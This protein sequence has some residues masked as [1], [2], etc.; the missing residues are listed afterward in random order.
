MEAS[1]WQTISI[2]G[3]S[4][5]AVLFIGAII[6]FFKLNIR[7]IIGDLTGRSAAKQIQ[8]IREQNAMSGNKRY[9]PGA[10]NLERGELTEPVKVR[11]GLFSGRFGK[12]SGSALTQASET[13]EGRG[14]T[15][16]QRPVKVRGHT[17]GHTQEHIDQA[18]GPIP[19]KVQGQVLE[20]KPLK[21][22]SVSSPEAAS[23]PTEV[24][25][26]KAVDHQD[27]VSI[28]EEGEAHLPP[29]TE[30]LGSE[31]EVLVAS[32]ETE[33][34]IVEAGDSLETEVLTDDLVPA[35]R[36]EVLSNSTDVLEPDI[37]TT[38]L[39]PTEELEVDETEIKGVDFK[40]V[41]DLKVT[42]TNQKI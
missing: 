18:R 30:V 34:L 7:A 5:S 10:F 4:L 13:L 16:G 17:R 28:F 38:V 1:T 14:Q 6:L 26:E 37:G 42:H 40:I 24:L 12:T 15:R 8:Q 35:N 36:T 27:S 29:E 3:Y 32:N 11:N 20:N 19:V 21:A 31:T 2:V 25:P 22:Q 23:L 39:Y 41:K 9:T 33:V